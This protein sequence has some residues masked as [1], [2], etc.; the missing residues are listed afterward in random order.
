MSRNRYVLNNSTPYLL[1]PA[2]YGALSMFI[3][4]KIYLVL[5]N[6]ERYRMGKIYANLQEMMHR[7]IGRFVWYDLEWKY[8]LL[9]GIFVSNLFN[10]LMDS[11]VS[12]YFMPFSF[13]IRNQFYEANNQWIYDNYYYYMRDKNRI[14]PKEIL[15]EIFSFA[16]IEEDF[17]LWID[18]DEC[19]IQYEEKHSYM[20]ELSILA[21]IW[22]SYSSYRELYD[23][24]KAKQIT[25]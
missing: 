6:Y 12:K 17:P 23:R 20:Q 7:I 14:L 1:I 24:I 9:S 13:K 11:V 18:N 10:F 5:R 25:A 3:G 22:F 15:C 16:G 4:T 2:C 19:R 8:L 21:H